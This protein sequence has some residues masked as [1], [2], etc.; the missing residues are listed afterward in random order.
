MNSK[1][2][3]VIQS[4]AVIWGA[5]ILL[6]GL[7]AA[8]G[9]STPTYTVNTTV[10]GLLSATRVVL[11]DNGRDN[12]TVSA[13][14][15]AAFHTQLA[16][17]SPYAV[18]VLTQP[19]GENCRV[20]GA[21][22]VV[23]NSNLNI[24][25]T[26]TPNSYSVGGSVSG[27]LSGNRVILQN[28]AANST[29]VSAN[30]S[31]TLSGQ[32]KSGS[33]YAVTVS[34]QPTGQTCSVTNGTGTVVGANITDVAVTCAVLSYNIDVN[35][36][37]LLPN[38][39]LVLQDNGRDNLTVSSAGTFTF[40]T[41]IPSGSAY[42]VTILSQ[43]AGQTCSVSS[44]SGTVAGAAVNVTVT[45]PWHV[46]YVANSGVLGGAQGSVSAF[47]IDPTTGA[48]SPVL[49]SPFS[50]GTHPSFVTTDKS[51]RF[52]YVSSLNSQ[53]TAD[54]IFP[55]SISATTGGL[56]A[57]PGN[58]VTG[59]ADTGPI[60]INPSDTF[61]YIEDGSNAVY[62]IDPTTGALTLSS[63]GGAGGGKSQNDFTIN[64][65]GTI[66]YGTNIAGGNPPDGGAVI[67]FSIGATNGVLTSIATVAAGNSPFDVGITPNGDF[68]YVSDSEGFGSVPG[69]T[70]GL[71]AYSI[72]AS[73]GALTPVAG[74]PFATG[75][76]PEI[77]TINPSGAFV[78]VVNY[79][80]S[81][82]SGYAIDQTSGALTPIAGSPFMVGS[83]IQDFK[84]DPSGKFA[85]AAN[86][87]DETLSGY[88]I[89]AT[90]GRLS[91]IS[92]SPFPVGGSGP[93]SI[94]ITAV[95]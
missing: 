86:V 52:A 81:T 9:A 11:Q 77:V 36:V 78:Y 92:G 20:A 64:P 34:T 14:G 48:L 57:I 89:D 26:C 6:A 40:A 58:P 76:Q 17:G 70:G 35:V 80:D 73:T 1:P 21:I 69:G 15:T 83:T 51:G 85:Y 41:A 68:A 75:N 62:A 67:E 5:L 50:A 44:G 2:I 7:L 82:I 79:Q 45:C 39:G 91:P 55:F 74:S 27:L 63:N 43:P 60:L 8:C 33:A 22:G 4:G 28:S 31:Y 30:G 32:I 29:S 3:R 49:G 38:A 37:G 23:A 93:T 94:A 53:E 90:T 12:L 10:S 13:N 56:T 84:I 87:D 72:N 19:T 18:T 16:S 59:S 46:L 71:S 47:I 25:V 88:T 61:A 65:A 42:Y 24:V 66:A 95:P 54:S